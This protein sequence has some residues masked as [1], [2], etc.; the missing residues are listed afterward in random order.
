[1]K[2]D[3]TTLM[4]VASL[5][6][7]A[8]VAFFLEAR[9]QRSSRRTLARVSDQGGGDPPSLHPKIDPALCIGCGNCVAACPEDDVL[10]V[11]DGRARLVHATHCVGH[12]RC[13]E[14]CPT[15]AL[16][17]VFGTAAR[18]VT[19]PLLGVDLQTSV[20]GI[21]VAGELGGFGLIRTAVNQGVQV[22]ENLSASLKPGRNGGATDVVIVGAGPAGI[23]AALACHERGLSHEILDQ[24]GLG[25]S[26]H[27]YP[28][29]K[30]VMTA[31]VRL[32]VIGSM[33]FKEITKEDLFAYW[34]DVIRKA[35]IK[36]SSPHRVA[37]IERDGREFRVLSGSKET[38]ARRVILAI[39]RR[40][41]PRTLGV[42]GEDGAGVAYRLIEPD[43]YNGSR[44]L[45]VGG[46][47]SAVEA[48][49]SLAEAGAQTVLSYR[50]DRFNRI[51]EANQAKLEGLRGQGLQVVLGS[52]VRAIEPRRA[53]LKDASG[54]RWIPNDHVFVLIG[55][56]LPT[57]FLEKVGVKTTTYYGE[58]PR[59]PHAAAP[60]A[61][62]S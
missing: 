62:A 32:P 36:I 2:V 22:I 30:L 43:Q 52:E 50:G 38:R 45:V 53:L 3:P 44:V 1:M 48:A 18:G 19:V 10:R 55:G 61:R 31:P 6:A 20:P 4:V 56:D 58:P 41:T 16:E 60:E 35:E 24:E 37:A 54:E 27:H 21:Y 17:L 13:K 8:V 23:A 15:G 29:R 51:A 28:R 5:G 49:V 25:G 26:V 9:R 34:T 7:V 12:G 59:A 14:V 46:G 42:P 33:N 40:G 11:I 57:Q 39:G 47:N